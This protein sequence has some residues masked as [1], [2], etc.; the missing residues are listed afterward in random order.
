ME[1]ADTMDLT[2]TMDSATEKTPTTTSQSITEEYLRFLDLTGLPVHGSIINIPGVQSL[3]HA[4]KVC[5]QD[6]SIPDT[7][8]TLACKML[9]TT[10]LQNYFPETQGYAV[11][12]T[13]LGPTAERGVSFILVA[14]D[15]PPASQPK[16]QAKK[17][18]K[19]QSAATKPKTFTFNQALQ[20]T[21]KL[22]FE[23]IQPE[24]IISFTV[25]RKLQS[26]D[27]NAEVVKTE[28]RVHTS[29]I[30]M[31]NRSSGTFDRPHSKDNVFNRG[32]MLADI[33]CQRGNVEHGYGIL[34]HGPRLEFYAYDAGPKWVYRDNGGKKPK[35]RREETPNYNE[36][37]LGPFINLIK[38]DDAGN[39]DLAFDV[40]YDSLELIDQAFR[41][42]A[43]R[44]V[45]YLDKPQNENGHVA[46]S[47]SDER[48]E[49]QGG[50]VGE[51]L[52][53]QSG[54]PV[55]ILDHVL[56]EQYPQ[57]T[58]TPIVRKQRTDGPESNES[59]H[60]PVP[61]PVEPLSP[62]MMMR[63]PPHQL[64]VP[65]DPTI[66]DQTGTGTEQ[67]TQ[68]PQIDMPHGPMFWEQ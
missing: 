38:K 41:T 51:V 61:P 2:N 9:A 15:N 66:L 37:D 49:M 53:D 16:G 18:A 30:I 33:L 42:I 32:D 1:L 12:Q 68:L 63:D 3:Y 56:P 43:S 45:T 35:T 24:N 19:K 28:D 52:H 8:Y 21:Y 23:T 39:E 40:R 7:V 31:M 65:V 64:P 17:K 34:L 54:G 22:T 29:L 10:L 20:Y 50:P 55:T 57:I 47:L 4:I 11:E 62:E 67:P 27:P 13:N 46:D 59:G 36:S 26:S 58:T 6:S 48:H 44:R 5:Y 25:K 14:D 60:E